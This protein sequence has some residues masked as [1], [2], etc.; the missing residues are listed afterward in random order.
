MLP[1]GPADLNP[2][3]LR[4]C[5]LRDGDVQHALVEI[6]LNL[7]L[8]H[9][10]RQLERPLERAIRAL[11][12]V[13]PPLLAFLPLGGFLAANRQRAV[14]DLDLDVLLPDAGKLDVEAQLLWG[15]ANVHRRMPVRARAAAEERVVEKAIDLTPQSEHGGEPEGS[16]VRHFLLLA[17][18][19]LISSRPTSSR[20]RVRSSKANADG[21][22]HR[23]T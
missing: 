6:G 17:N 18:R 22:C 2:P 15:L 4:K 5:G 16:F 19:L 9:A 23:G 21:P 11:H 3:R 7:L 13:E 10:L 14:L 1:G 12:E 8:V 20:A